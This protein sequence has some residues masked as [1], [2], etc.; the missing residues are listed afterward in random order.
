MNINI[1]GVTA[2]YR[3]TRVLRGIDWT[4]RSGVTG[5]LG[6]NG[7]GKTTLLSVM[8]GLLHPNEGSVTVLG[9]ARFGLV[10]QRFSMPSGMRLVDA[11]SY[12]A[13]LN[14][15]AAGDSEPAARRALAAVDL[16]SYADVKVR[17]LSD[18]QRQCAG[19]AAGLVHEPDVL[20]L[21]EPTAGLDTG[22]RWRVQDLITEIGRT[23][24]VMVSTHLLDDV[25]YL[26]ERVGVLTG[27]Q[28]V[29]D[30]TVA[31]LEA[32]GY[33]Q[34]AD[35]QRSALEAGYEGLLTTGGI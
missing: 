23:H 30:G 33:D 22:Q 25:S 20:V 27:G 3:G 9:G 18:G 7:S 35:S 16:A 1:E 15:M 6:P 17:T 14:G 13:W 28:L 8:V 34:P 31:E 29:F 19:I 4:V 21:D 10:P 2:Y 5:L 24:L 11:V 26:C 32:A 12:T